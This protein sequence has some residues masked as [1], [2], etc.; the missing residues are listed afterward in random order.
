[1]NLA[2]HDTR[3]EQSRRPEW[4][5]FAD[6]TVR[7]RRNAWWH[8]ILRH[9]FAVRGYPK[10][11]GLRLRAKRRS[12][13]YILS[14]RRN[15]HVRNGPVWAIDGLHAQADAPTGPQGR[16]GLSGIF[17]G[18]SVKTG[19]SRRPILDIV[20]PSVCAPQRLI[21]GEEDAFAPKRSPLQGPDGL[22]VRCADPDS[23]TTRMRRHP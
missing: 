1:M 13:E 18:V 20:S 9:S 23:S 8:A 3:G 6:R 21:V 11:S 17:A 19:R 22:E 10:N 15:I 7:A 16:I 2:R 4:A 12:C 14:A 5:R